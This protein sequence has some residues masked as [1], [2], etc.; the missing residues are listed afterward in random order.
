MNSITD[1]AVIFFN[2]LVDLLSVW[3]PLGSVVAVTFAAYFVATRMVP[4]ARAN[5]VIRAQRAQ[6]RKS[7][8]A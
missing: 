8:A 6:A 2:L 7:L 4:T 5:A 3:G 1:F